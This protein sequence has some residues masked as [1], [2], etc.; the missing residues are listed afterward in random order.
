MVQ[1]PLKDYS[2]ANARVRAMNARLL[3]MSVYKELLDAPDYNRALGVLE[4]TEYGDDIEQFMLEGARPTTLDRAFNRNLIRNFARIKD[5]FIGRP[6]EMVDDL[7]AR[8]DLYNLKTLIRGMRALIPK[9]EISRNLVPIGSLDLVTL[10]EIINQPDLRASLD[11]IVMFS[12]QWRIPYGR[13]I[14]A[15]LSD[16]LREHDLSILELALDKFH[17]EKITELLK[18]GDANNALVREVVT[19]EVD[20]INITTLMR[21]CGLELEESKAEDYFIPGGSIATARDFARVME[22]GQPERVYEALCTK[23]PY[24]DPLEKAWK[25]FDERGENAFEDEMEKHMIRTCLKMSK[26]PL[27][28]GVIIEYM[29]KKYLEI[30]N[31]RIIVRGKSIGLLES[32][33]RK[34]IFLW[35]EES[36]EK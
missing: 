16:Y 6:E 29:W 3:D 7:L 4:E 5:F 20:S 22:L 17:Y 30:T 24:R 32:Q 18:G 36:R 23:T 8:W 27:G 33:I 9:A 35:D 12:L 11:T 2:Y 13:A 31:L 15:H 10:E 26:D 1:V 21:I 28:I 34:E 14:T 19:M 25:D